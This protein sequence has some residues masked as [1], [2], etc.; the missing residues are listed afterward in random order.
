VLCGRIYGGLDG[1]AEREETLKQDFPP[2][3][4]SGTLYVML[5]MGVKE[6]NKLGNMRIA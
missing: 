6:G 3:P 5:R 4:N 2:T 1:E